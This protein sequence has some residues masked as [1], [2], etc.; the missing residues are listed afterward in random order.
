MAPA[1]SQSG[2]LPAPAGGP[3]PVRPCSSSCSNEESE[4]DIAALPAVDKLVAEL[5]AST[6]LSN[7]IKPAYPYRLG[8]EMLETEPEVR[9]WFESP[10]HLERL[11][12]PDET[13]AFVR[14][15]KNPHTGGVVYLI[16]TCHV[17]KAA[18][19]DVKLLIEAVEPD[20]VAVEV[21]IFDH[22]RRFGSWHVRRQKTFL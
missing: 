3:F 13:K 22:V 11:S 7:T 15:L 18:G 10:L 17:S 5:P 1:Q 19:E 8:L 20:V 16:G 6:P 9:S 4:L 21:S 14:V 12:L 2:G